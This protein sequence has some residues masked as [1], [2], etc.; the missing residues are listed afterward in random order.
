MDWSEPTNEEHNAVAGFYAGS[1][2]QAFKFFILVAFIMLAVMTG[3]IVLMANGFTRAVMLVITSVLTTAFFGWLL[4]GSDPRKALI[5]NRKYQV[6]RCKVSD[7]RIGN[8]ARKIKYYVT[9]RCPDGSDREYMAES[10]IYHIAKPGKDVLLVD[11]SGDNN[12][13]SKAKRD[14][15]IDVVVL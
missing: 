7:R 6:C 2:V 10:F 15:H 14:I 9:V 11:Y 5:M 1:K 3:G 12:G 8:A 13:E 4:L